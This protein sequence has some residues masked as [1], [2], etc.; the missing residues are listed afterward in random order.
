MENPG[1]E[2]LL[3]PQEV[4]AGIVEA[5]DTTVRCGDEDH[6][7]GVVEEISIAFFAGHE[8]RGTLADQAL[9]LGLAPSQLANQ[10]TITRPQEE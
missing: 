8:L 10:Q 5:G 6:V 4:F 7:T 3:D 9:E 2:A 1:I